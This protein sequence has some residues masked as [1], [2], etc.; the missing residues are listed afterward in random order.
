MQFADPP[1]KADEPDP[2]DKPDD[3]AW[4]EPVDGA[5]PTTHP[6]K[7]NAQSGIFHVPGGMSYERTTPER[8]YSSTEAAEADGFRQAKR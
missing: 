6:V 7:G 5:C 8:C 1:D 2:P 3:R 4:V